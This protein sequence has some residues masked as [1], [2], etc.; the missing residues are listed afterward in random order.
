MAKIKEKLQDGTKK[1]KE[2]YSGDKKKKRIGI[3][4]A[5]LAIVIAASV[6][7]AV[8][9]NQKEYIS[10]FTDL[11]TEDL[12]SV[13]ATLQE[14]G[15]TDYKVKDD[16]ILVNSKDESNIRANLLL[17]GYPKSGFA[18]ETYN[19]QLSMMTSESARQ[20]A[21]VQD[22]QDRMGATIECL[23]GVKQAVVNIQTGSDNR[24][25][26]DSENSTPAS[27]SVTVIMKNDEE[28]PDKYVEAIGNMILTA[29]S[30]LEFE[31]ITITDSLGNTFSQ[32]KMNQKKTPQVHLI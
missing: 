10:L 5:A 9:L 1:I 18:Y 22:L 31:N 28:I 16:S 6:F 14:Q 8:K 30:G 11:T 13:V 20:T 25:V 2:F 15:V 26:L 27:A 7:S 12:S 3:T 21:I 17:D 24:Y 29:V 19:S 32:D 4:S 23:E